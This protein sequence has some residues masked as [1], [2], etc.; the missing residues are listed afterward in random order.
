MVKHQSSH[1]SPRNPLTS[2]GLRL[3]D[4]WWRA[5]NYLSVGMIYL[6]RHVASANGLS[7]P[8]AVRTPAKSGC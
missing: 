2:E 8:C 1:A 3:M 7:G 5:C 6:S 4:G